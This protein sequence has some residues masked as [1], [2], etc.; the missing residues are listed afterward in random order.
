MFWVGWLWSLKLWFYVE[1]LEPCDKC[2]LGTAPYSYE[3][4]GALDFKLLEG[5]LVMF[6]SRA[7]EM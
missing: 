4:P 3:Q 1:R 2:L 6:F 7:A 5:R